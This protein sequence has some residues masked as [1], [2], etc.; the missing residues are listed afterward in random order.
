MHDN[1]LKAGATFDWISPLLGFIQDWMYGPAVG[2]SIPMSAGW[3]TD[4]ISQILR[5]NGIKVWGVM[6]SGDVI[7]LS[8][9]RQQARFAAY[10]MQRAGIPFAS[11]AERFLAQSSSGRTKRRRRGPITRRRAK[12]TL[13]FGQRMRYKR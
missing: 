2:F 12:H 3:G 6:L 10:L 8:T 5:S 11:N 4:T 13:V 9:R 1:I 7:L